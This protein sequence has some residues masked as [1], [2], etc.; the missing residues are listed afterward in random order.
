MSDHRRRLD[1]VRQSLIVAETRLAD[2][3]SAAG[4][5]IKNVR[6]ALASTKRTGGAHALLVA[7][8]DSSRDVVKNRVE[9]TVELAIQAVFGKSRRFRFEVEIKRGVVSMTPLI[10]YLSPASKVAPG[11]DPRS[12]RWKGWDKTECGIHV[13]GAASELPP[14]YDPAF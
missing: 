7:L 3:R 4:N 14:G 8:A 13:E 9:S 5:A 2:A 10:G 6:L 1:A 11:E 12:G